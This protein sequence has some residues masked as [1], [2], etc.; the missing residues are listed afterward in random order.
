MPERRVQSLYREAASDICMSMLCNAMR[1]GCR[2]GRR[3]FPLWTYGQRLPKMDAR[4]MTA[5]T[6]IC[7]WQSAAGKEV[8]SPS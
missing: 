2:F 7:R 5:Q 3:S 8:R 6:T 4:Y 1:R